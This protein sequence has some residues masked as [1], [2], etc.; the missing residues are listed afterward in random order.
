MATTLEDGAR[1]AG[2]RALAPI[3]WTPGKHGDA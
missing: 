3:G 2:E 1:A